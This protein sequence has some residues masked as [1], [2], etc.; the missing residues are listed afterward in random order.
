MKKNMYHQNLESKLLK[1]NSI[2]APV[3]KRTKGTLKRI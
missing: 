2:A 3:N 1:I